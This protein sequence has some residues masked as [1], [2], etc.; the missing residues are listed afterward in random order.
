MQRLAGKGSLLS[1]GGVP[2]IVSSRCSPR[3]RSAASEPQYS[4]KSYLLGVRLATSGG[5]D[6]P[7]STTE[8]PSPPYCNNLLSPCTCST[9]SVVLIIKRR[10]RHTFPMMESG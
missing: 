4:S 6:L 3:F 9:A 10:P 7:R 2:T 1:L 5:R 8:P